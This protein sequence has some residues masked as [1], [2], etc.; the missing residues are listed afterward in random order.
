MTKKFYMKP[1][2]I[3][4]VI[5]KDG[6]TINSI[7]TESKGHVQ[8]YKPISMGGTTNEKHP[9]FLIKANTQDSIDTAYKMIG[10]IARESY[11]R[12]HGIFHHSCPPAKRFV[13]KPKPLP[14]TIQYIDQKLDLKYMLMPCKCVISFPPFNLGNTINNETLN[15]IIGSTCSRC[16]SQY[17]HAI[18]AIKTTPI[19]KYRTRT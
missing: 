3:G 2:D 11:N 16:N 7:K 19:T 18:K 10:K 8:I 9:Y 4:F 17:T 12:R 1:K 6:A 15:N 5:G 13:P 14:P